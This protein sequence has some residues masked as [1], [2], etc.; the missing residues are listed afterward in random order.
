[1][2]LASSISNKLSAVKKYRYKWVF[3]IALSW[4][5]VDVF[6]WQRYVR[7]SADLKYDSTFQYLS[8]GAIVLRIV[9]VFYMSAVMGYL[10]VFRLK[11]LFREYPM[12][13]NLVLKTAILLVASII[14]N[15]LLHFSY[16]MIILN[17]GMPQAFYNFYYDSSHTPWF[18]NSNIIWITMFVMTQML[19]EIN[20]KYSPGVYFDIV[21]GKYMKP[22]IE[23]RIIMFIDLKDSTPIAEKL[24]HTVYFRFIRDFIYY[25]SNAL[26]EYNGRIYQYVGDEIVVSWSYSE[27]NV[28]KCIQSLIEARKALQKHGV[29]FK[30]KYGTQPEFRV[31]VHLGEV[32]VGE[33]GI[34][35]RDLAMSGDTMNTTARIRTACSELNTRFIVSKDF[36]DELQMKHWQCESLGSIDLKGK[37]NSIEL[38]ALI[39]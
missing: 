9:I 5:I 14:M 2:K 4:T 34:L 17:T 32:T 1:M 27:E 35:K 37:R 36:R 3:L 8:L 39:I 21:M 29:E 13:I 16:S 12:I 33:I 20:E 28:Q 26:L 22:R 18:W 15:F 30:R 7:T 25:I 38:F 10:L 24:G 19:L 31:G 6:L 11:R 23:K